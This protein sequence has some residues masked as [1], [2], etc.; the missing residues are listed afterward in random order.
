MNTCN[1]TSNVT[2]DENLSTYYAIRM[3]NNICHFA[4]PP[5]SSIAASCRSRVWC[6]YDCDVLF[7]WTCLLQVAWRWTKWRR[8]HW[9]SSRLDLKVASAASRCLPR[10]TS[11]S[12]MTSWTAR[13]CA[14]VQFEP[15]DDSHA[16]MAWHWNVAFLV[17][18]CGVFLY[19][20][21][22]KQL[23]ILALHV[24]RA[25]GNALANLL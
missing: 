4:D 5:L 14:N 11:S 23:F 12:W 15:A 2:N 8:K 21:F 19:F 3:V 17:L 7:G 22:C 24:D 6:V 9:R 10:I 18:M 16:Q 20:N 13:T 25:N 1:V